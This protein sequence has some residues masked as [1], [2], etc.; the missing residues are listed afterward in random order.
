MIKKI[1]AQILYEKVTELLSVGVHHNRLYIKCEKNW[2]AVTSTELAIIIRSLYRDEEQKLISTGTV[3]EV[4]ERLLQAPS[5]QLHFIEETDVQ[6][7]KLREGVF[8]VEKGSLNENV[9]GDFGYYLNFSYTEKSKRNMR[10]FEGY[11]HSVFSDDYECKKRLMLE[12]LGYVLSDYTKAKSG[13]FFIGASN[14]GK[15]T[16][17]ELVKRVLPESAVTTIPLY[18]LENRFNL[19]RL[20]DARVNIC[21]ELSEKSFSS[22]DIFKMLTSN[23]V[24]T[25]EHKGCKPF[26]FRMKCKSLNAGN[27]LPDI[28]GT[29]GI[30][31]IINRMVIL[32]FTKSI[33]REN[34]DL[35]LLDK[36][37]GERGSIFSEALDALVELKKR[38]F[39]FTEPEDSKKLK[40]QLQVQEDS[41][42]TFIAERCIIEKEAREHLVE[43]YSA[44]CEYCDENLLECIYSKTQFSQYLC[45]KP[46]IR[47]EKFRIN[48]SKPLSGMKGIRLKTRKEYDGQDSEVY[49]ENKIDSKKQDNKVLRREV[50]KLCQSLNSLMEKIE[51]KGH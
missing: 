4:I 42:D 14:S 33:S 50:E 3:H 48:G 40:Q 44:F 20:A 29:E 39:I 6:F 51:E 9:V 32:L 34:Q 13:F 47:R 27:M 43:L 26:E 1:D 41:L 12:V 28:K 46:N 24:V 15:S 17:L 7:L 16:V 22:V 35:G 38:N 10:N 8:D 30:G 49:S 21:T 11:L 5:L 31:A 23:E 37:W 36:L 2:N 25:A 19:A 45:R 18:R